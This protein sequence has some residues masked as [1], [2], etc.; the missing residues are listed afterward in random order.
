MS[1]EAISVLAALGGALIGA[2]AAVGGTWWQGHAAG[3]A[4]EADARER[5]YVDLLVASQ[6]LAF[7]MDTLLTTVKTRS[8]LGEGLAV[9]LG[10]RKPM[11]AMVL[12]DWLRVDLGPLMDAWSRAWA[13]ASP[14]GVELSNAVLDA[15]NQMF[16]VLGEGAAQTPL[17]KAR[18]AV[19]GAS[20]D[21]Q[22]T[23][24]S[25]RSRVLAAARKDLAEL[26]RAETGRPPAQLFG[27][28]IDQ[29]AREE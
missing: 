12:H 3:K 17:I 2:L 14:R 27:P 28:D 20:I 25:E 19:V 9:T 18:T 13:C 6:N 11:D 26:V 5:A 15:C 10:Q 23:L 8:G 29:K 4:A 1:G 24:L 7:R 22:R 16:A 21:E